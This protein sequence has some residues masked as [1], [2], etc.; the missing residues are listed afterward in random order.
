MTVMTAPRG[1]RWRMA[2]AL[3]ALTPALGLGPA[4]SASAA[5]AD[6]TAAW[7][8]GELN[9]ANL[10]EGD[11]GPDYGLTL[12]GIVA[13]GELGV[14][15]STREAMLDAVAADPQAYISGEAFGDTGS[16][17]AGPTGKL[18]A[19][20]QLA[21]RSTTQNSVDLLNRLR[22]TLAPA[23]PEAGRAKDIS[24]FGDFSNGVGQTWVVRAFALA[25]DDA[26][27]P[28]TDFLLRQQ[29]ADG[30]FRVVYSDSTGYLDPATSCTSTADSTSFAIFALL[31]ADDA[32]VPGLDD[33]IAD[34]ADYLL[35]VQ[36]AD[37]SFEGAGVGSS[38]STGLAALALFLLGE[39]DAA[40]RAA[41]WV[42]STVLVTPARATGPLTGE[43]GAIAPSAATFA[44][45]QAEG[46]TESLANPFR[47][48]T[49]QAALALVVPAP[50]APAPGPGPSVTPPAT[51]T[52]GGSITVPVTNPRAVAGGAGRV[53]STD[54]L[55]NTGSG[56]EPWMLV[57]G[58]G[59]V[60]AGAAVLVGSRRRSSNR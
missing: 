7:I 11:F 53:A 17:Y 26:V 18:A 3:A 39:D 9:A 22:S 20:L 28:A 45:A 14:G 42:R 13:L 16:T 38:N 1:R 37:G 6:D 52:G 23:G 44:Q 21:G 40:Q 57:A 43:A 36:A 33:D 51:G 55:P 27:A 25:G 58:A 4:G 54:R 35:S 60:I 41:A 10:L 31:D 59:A 29:C 12:D 32:G 46:I 15:T 2:A 48:A 49:M 50:Q 8:A 5:E 34:A 24:S 56:T 47:R 19:V 30:G